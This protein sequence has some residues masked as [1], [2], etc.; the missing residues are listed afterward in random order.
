MKI[1]KAKLLKDLRYIP[2]CTL[3]QG[4]IVTIRCNDDL[5][6]WVIVP[7]P[8]MRIKVFKH[9]YEIESEE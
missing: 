5:Q 3:K 2:G 4:D 1:F 6:S 8:M 9:E 7:D